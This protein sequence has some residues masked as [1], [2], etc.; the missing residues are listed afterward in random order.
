MLRLAGN[1]TG[2]RILLTGASGGVGHYVTE[3]ATAAGAEVTVV[4]AIDQAALFGLLDRIGDLGLVL[5]SVRRLDR[6]R[7]DHGSRD[8]APAG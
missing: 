6:G 4:T 7:G 3:L 1:V 8:A 2:R 5:I